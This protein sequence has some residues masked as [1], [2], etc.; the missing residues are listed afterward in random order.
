MSIII[1]ISLGVI[2][3]CSS[4]FGLGDVFARY[5][6]FLDDF[7][8]WRKSQLGHKSDNNGNSKFTPWDN[9][10][11]NANTMIWCTLTDNLASDM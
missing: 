11:D 2:S 4:D 9:F 5:C 8:N 7:H 3:P 10:R 1:S 6:G